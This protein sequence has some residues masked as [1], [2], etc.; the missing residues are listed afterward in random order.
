MMYFLRQKLVGKL[1]EARKPNGHS[2]DYQKGR[3]DTLAEV[4]QT[5]NNILHYP[6]PSTEDIPQLASNNSKD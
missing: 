2:T 1:V 3:A 4:I 6:D 5:V